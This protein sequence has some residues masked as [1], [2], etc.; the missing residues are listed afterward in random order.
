MNTKLRQ[1]AKSHFEKDL[2]K[3]MNKAVF[4]KTIEN[5]IKCGDIKLVTTESNK[6]YLV[7]KSNYHTLKC[8][9]E[10]LLA[11]EMKETQILMNKSVYIGLSILELSKAVMNEVWHDYVKPKFGSNSKLCYMDT[12]NFIVHVKTNN[13]TYKD[14]AEY[15]EKI[16]D[17]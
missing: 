15:V 8:F 6:N 11:I 17:T 13:D 5:V 12:E 4:G 14:I 7:S 10:N 9:T 2:F 1:K 3:L 16:P